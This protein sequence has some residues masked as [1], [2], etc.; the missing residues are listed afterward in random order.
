[1][2]NSHH[3]N[4]KCICIRY[5]ISLFGVYLY[6]VRLHQHCIQHSPKYIL[7]TFRVDI[8]LQHSPRVVQEIKTFI[9]QTHTYTKHHDAMFM[10]AIR[11]MMR[12]FWSECFC[13]LIG[14][15]NIRVCC[16]CLLF[17]LDF[18]GIFASEIAPAT[19]RK[20]YFSVLFMS[21]FNIELAW[22]TCQFVVIRCKCLLQFEVQ[23][24]CA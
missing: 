22:I 4:Q 15:W 6:F 12:L 19:E 17:K 20:Q 18:I 13:S 5:W 10:A 7:F 1:M 24:M 14:W 8:V 23:Q 11:E 2:E 16:E 21:S 9:Q 3:E